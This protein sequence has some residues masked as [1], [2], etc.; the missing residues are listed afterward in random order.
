MYEGVCST[1]DAFCRGGGGDRRGSAELFLFLITGTLTPQPPD[2]LSIA[3]LFSSINR[4]HI[5]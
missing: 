2:P 5:V 4:F 3:C 1:V